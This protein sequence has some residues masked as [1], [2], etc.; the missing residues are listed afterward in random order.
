M[1]QP[2]PIEPNP[3]WTSSSA[4]STSS[5]SIQTATCDARNPPLGPQ[6][7]RHPSDVAG[8]LDRLATRRHTPHVDAGG[9]PGPVPCHWRRGGP[10]TLAGD[11]G[12]GR[13][14]PESS[15]YRDPS[16]TRCRKR[17]GLIPHRSARD[18]FSNFVLGDGRPVS[19]EN[20]RDFHAAHSTRRWGACGR[21]PASSRR[22]IPVGRTNRPYISG[23]VSICRRAAT[24]SASERGPGPTGQ[25]TT[26]LDDRTRRQERTSR[27]GRTRNLPQDRKAPRAAAQ[28]PDGG[29]R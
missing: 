25:W 11:T 21:R 9:T 19:R 13:L 1:V 22:S 3:P 24:T 27:S 14:R 8:R 6:P 15:A 5:S 28:Q 18:A 20:L 10:F 16:E 29:G 26:G 23:S 12:N 2:T 7:S 4:Q 17:L